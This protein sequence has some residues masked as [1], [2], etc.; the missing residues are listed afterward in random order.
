MSM[1][2]I[3]LYRYSDAPR[4]AKV[5]DEL[6]HAH[7]DETFRVLEMHLAILHDD[8]EE[9][10]RHALKWAKEALFAPEASSWAVFLLNQVENHLDDAI[11]LGKKALRRMPAAVVVANNTAY[12]LALAGHANQAKDFLRRGRNGKMFDLATQGLICAVKGDI[13]EA[14]NFYDRAENVAEEDGGVSGSVLVNLHRRLIGVVSPEV[15]PAE[16]AKPVILPKDWDDFPSIV[17]CLRMLKRRQ[18]PLDQI[19]ID[20]TSAPLPERIEPGIS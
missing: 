10:T 19:T 8:S 3:L 6:V 20:G 9:A 4:L 14:N 1:V 17:M 18:A 16:I 13:R 11:K 5:R 12:S 2:P 15:N 7:P